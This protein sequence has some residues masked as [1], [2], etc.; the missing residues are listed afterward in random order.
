MRSTDTIGFSGA[1]VDPRAGGV[2]HLVRFGFMP[3]LV[4]PRGCGVVGCSGGPLHLARAGWS[5]DPLGSSCNPPVDP[6]PCG[7]TPRE[8]CRAVPVPVH[9]RGLWAFRV[10]AVDLAVRGD[11]SRG[12]ESSIS[13]VEPRLNLSVDSRLSLSESSMLH[14]VLTRLALS[15]PAPLRQYI[16]CPASD[17]ISLSSSASSWLL[18]L[19]ISSITSAM[20]SLGTPR[21]WSTISC[22]GLLVSYVART[23]SFAA[24]RPAAGFLAACGKSR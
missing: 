10:V 16:S 2:L 5:A 4:Y 12:A 6:R 20:I 7:E 13:M 23:S 1:P 19:S 9:P 11:T 14:L 18:S 17:A 22:R 24:C 15:F 21:R 3:S 8:G